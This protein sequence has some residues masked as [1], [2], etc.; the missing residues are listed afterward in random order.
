M[1]S[2][3]HN[4]MQLRFGNVWETGGRKLKIIFPGLHAYVTMHLPR[5]DMQSPVCWTIVCIITNRIIIDPE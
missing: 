5:P 1:G 2:G 4:Q 3:K